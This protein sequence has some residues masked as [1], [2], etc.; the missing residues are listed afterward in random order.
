MFSFSC[1]LLSELPAHLLAKAY[2]MMLALG[3]LFELQIVDFFCMPASTDTSK[4]HIEREP[5]WIKRGLLIH[6]QQKRLLAR[7]GADQST[8]VVAGLS[9][10]EN[11][12]LLI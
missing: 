3:L 9:K 5:S 4:N 12:S 11:H 1:V 6:H 8:L 7:C 10:R 2:Q